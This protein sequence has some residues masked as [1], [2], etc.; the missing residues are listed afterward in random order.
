MQFSA[1]AK[2]VRHSPYKLRPLADV[3]RG[4]SAQYALAWL[5][6]CALP[7]A[8]PLRKLIASAV[9]NA[10][11]VKGVEIN[12]LN[13]FELRVDEGPRI[14]YYRPG[15]MGRSNIYKKRL[16]HMSVVLK[17]ADDKQGK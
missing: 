16:C 8:K 4:K 2:F 3:V 12:G 17:S 15:A 1:K 6:T 11:D 14:R 10:R 5:D 7:K 13:I 9:A